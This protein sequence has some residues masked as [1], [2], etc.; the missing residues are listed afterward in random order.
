MFEGA[1]SFILFRESPRPI[2][3]ITPRMGSKGLLFGAGTAGLMFAQLL[4]Q[5]GGCYI[6][7]AG[8]GG[9]KL[10]LAESLDAVDEYVELPCEAQAAAALMENLP[11]RIH[12]DSDIV[13]DATGCAKILEMR[14]ILW[15]RV[16]N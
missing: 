16:E 11:G 6:V 13:V 8:P 3:K 9:L 2:D 10:E 15:P 7:I 5:N 14:S 1:W 4:R 12:V